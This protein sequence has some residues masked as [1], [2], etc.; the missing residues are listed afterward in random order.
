MHRSVV[1]HLRCLLEDLHAAWLW[2]VLLSKRLSTLKKIRD[3]P[4]KVAQLQQQ[5]VLICNRTQ[6]CQTCNRN[7]WRESNFFS[8]RC[9]GKFHPETIKVNNITGCFL[10]CS[11]Q[12]LS[13]M[14][15]LHFFVLAVQAKCSKI[16]WVVWTTFTYFKVTIWSLLL[17]FNSHIIV[18][19]TLG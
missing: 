4:H 3:T 5:Q 16:L 9:F 2:W 19:F 15:R 11:L 6:G 12:T 17:K 8:L 1:I 13:F 7:A 14:L 18:L 10:S